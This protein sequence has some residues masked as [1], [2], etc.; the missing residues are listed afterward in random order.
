MRKRPESVRPGEADDKVRLP[1][2]LGIQ[3]GVYLSVLYG[4]VILTV[5]FF[6]CVYPGLSRPGSLV[7]FRSEPWGAAIRAGGVNR[8]AAPEEFFLERGSHAVE[9]ALPGFE[10]RRFELNVPGRTFFSLFFPRRLEVRERLVTADPLSVIAAAAGDYAAWSFT[11]EP[12]GAYQ[13]PLSLSEGVY[14]AG[15]FLEGKEAEAAELIRAAARFAASQASLRDLSRAKLLLDNGGRAP[16]PLSLLQSAGDILSWLSSAPGAEAWLEALLPPEAAARVRDSGGNSPW[17]SVPAADRGNAGTDSGALPGNA[18]TGPAA[19]PGAGGA[20]DQGALPPSIEAGGLLFRRLDALPGLYYCETTVDSA[21]WEEFLRDRPEWAPEN[22]AGL[23]EQKLVTGDYLVSPAQGGGS[24]TG[25]SWYGAEAFCRWLGG[26]LPRG[27]EGWEARLPGEAEWEALPPAANSS[28]P[29]G[30]WEWCGDPYAPFPAFPAAPEAAA[31]VSSPERA[32]RKNGM[33]RASLPP[34]FCSP[35][36]GFRP[37]LAPR[38][39]P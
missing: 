22:T 8:G 18:G 25:V 35:F 23:M 31:A 38:N 9:L 3:P 12:T 5:L 26:R 33:P 24:R 39:R 32:L 28:A 14:R 17:S 19:V 27:L 34:E 11:G 29:E 20:A 2:I 7:S 6:L 1:P 16:S 30:L 4:L 15:P 21:A 36:A 13:I 10:T 37:L